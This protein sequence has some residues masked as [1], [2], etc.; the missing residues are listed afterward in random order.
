[1]DDITELRRSQRRHEEAA[2]AELG[3]RALTSDGVQS[4]MDEAVTLLASA[5]DVEIGSVAELLPG[6]EQLV[7]RA[8]HGWS[9]GAVG[10][11]TSP[12]G[13]GSIVGYTLAA[14]APV[15]SPDL[16]AEERFARSPALRAEDARSGLCVVIAGR[17]EPFGAL[18]AFDRR[19]RSFAAADVAFAQALANVL[20]AAVQRSQGERAV[21][22]T[23][24][25]ERR[26][27]A[28]NL[29]DEALQDLT[30]ALAQA[31]A[32]GLRAPDFDEQR[33]QLIQTL[34]RVGSQMRGAVFDLR[35]ASEDSRPF[36]ELLNGLVASQRALANGTALVLDIAG[37][38]PVDALAATGT[39][40][41][42]IIGEALV[43]A[44]RHAG[45]TEIRISVWGSPQRLCVVVADDG[46][47]FDPTTAE[48]GGGSGLRGM[49]ERTALLDG[50]L[51]LS[52]A[53]PSGTQVQLEV[54]LA[55]SGYAAGSAQVLI[56][57]EDSEIGAAIAARLAQQ[58]GIDV[59]AQEA[60]IS[61][62][63]PLLRAID[64]AV[65]DPALADG[66]GSKLIPELHDA[67]RHAQAILLSARLTPEEVARGIE[68]G[69]AASLDQSGELEQL[70][71]LILRLRAG[72][73]PL[74]GP[75][76]LALLRARR[77]PERERDDRWAVEQLTTRER[78]VL[79]RLS[80]GLDTTSIAARLFITPGA[81]RGHIAG[82][83]AKL[84]ART[85]LQAVLA[86]G[87]ADAG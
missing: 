21:I 54:P 42:R 56:L 7:L 63:R 15:L 48:A 44:R 82:I 18:G 24:E 64:V 70:A 77:T 37:S 55:G 26:R 49:R 58:P 29:H 57:G 75:A 60:R 74:P 13:R 25:T 16:L 14:G 31:A 8:G 51:D 20:S 85:Q 5:L 10:S 19:P 66:D 87:F 35:L 22:R 45:A 53:S 17:D 23:K 47:G 83:L 78:D 61:A 46:C 65:L 81:T 28:R 30:V 11:V 40:V 71:G 34:K 32:L 38:A 39:E 50:R 41:L 76:V 43:N 72:A 59:V 3:L 52:S 86:G 67:N 12:A 73:T 2:L 62:A 80:E 79:Q 69:A 68:L 9:N 36:P 1:M 33:A 6:G 27:I 4:L 84:G